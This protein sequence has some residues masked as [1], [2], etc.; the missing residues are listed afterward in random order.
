MSIAA[1][2]A[3]ALVVVSGVAGVVVSV[4]AVAVEG[5]VLSLLLPVSRLYLL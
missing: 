1:V 2:V 3:I 4:A 5:D